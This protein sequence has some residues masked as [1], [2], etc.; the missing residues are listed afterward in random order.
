MAWALKSYPLSE[1]NTVELGILPSNRYLKL[2][3]DG[4]RI[5]KLDPRYIDY[6]ESIKGHKNNISH[7]IIFSIF[8]TILF[9]FGIIIF[10]LN[11]ICKISSVRPFMSR[12]VF[13]NLAKCFWGIRN[14]LP[15]YFKLSNNPEDLHIPEFKILKD[16]PQNN[17]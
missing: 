7:F 17:S 14:A 13:P 12:T 3:K 15:N 10:I 1:C 8:G 16:S 9:P 5:S 6:L 2:L 4:A 11:N